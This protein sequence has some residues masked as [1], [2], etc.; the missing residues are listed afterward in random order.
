MPVPQRHRRHG[1]DFG[2]MPPIGPRDIS[3]DSRSGLVPIVVMIVA[4]VFATFGAFVLLMPVSR[5]DSTFFVAALRFVIPTMIVCESSARAVPVAF[6]VPTVI[7]VRRLPVRACVRR[8]RPVT[9]VPEI[10]AGL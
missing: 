7:V 8:A 2:R 5:F 10:V 3:S 4:V 9:V 1:C 6:D